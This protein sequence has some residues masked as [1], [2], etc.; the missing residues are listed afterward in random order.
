VQLFGLGAAAPR[1]RLQ[2]MGAAFLAC[3]PDCHTAITLV[4]RTSSR[5]KVYKPAVGGTLAWDL[6]GG[7]ARA[8]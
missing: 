6:C 7:C 4:V 2:H 5:M 1:A 8:A 3:R